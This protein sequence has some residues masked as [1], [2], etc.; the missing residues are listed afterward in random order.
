M[1][2][3]GMIYVDDCD[4][5]VFSQDSNATD[6]AI[7]ALQK[8]ILLW[9]EGLQVTGGALSLKKCSWGLLSYHRCG[10]H[11]LPHNHT[12][13]P[14]EVYIYD[15][16]GQPTPITRLHPN[17]GLEVVGVT[18]SLLGDPTPAIIAFQK[19]VDSWLEILRSN[20]LPHALVWKTLLQVLWPSLWYPLAI[21]T[22]RPQQANQLVSRL[23]QTLLPHLGVN[24]HFL[25]A[26]HYAV[27]KY[28][29][30]GLP[31]PFWEQGISALCLFLEHANAQSTESVLLHASLELLYLELGISLN[32][33]TLPY[34]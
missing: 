33:F 2:L 12:S 23:Y 29:G 27:P 20:F 8:N 16:V 18:Q 5:L 11:W 24:R 10:Y 34:A 4:L 13:A 32:L 3:T 15:T 25:L 22:F 26:L 17:E 9:Q 28:H 7:Q 31:S 30:L 21:L 1:Q 19:K 6:T 14:Q